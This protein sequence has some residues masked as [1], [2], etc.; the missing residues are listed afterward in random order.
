MRLA[1]PFYLSE[2]VLA[3][4]EKILGKYLCTKING[5][6][7]AGMIVETEAYMAPDDKA[8]HAFQN[9]RTNRTK[10]MFESGGIAYVYLCYGIHHLFNIVTGPRDMAHAILVR[11]VEP[12]EGLETMLKRRKMNQ[13]SYRLTGGPGSLSSALGITTALTGS[14]L[15]RKDSKVWLEDRG[16]QVQSVIKSPRV[17]V[18]YAEECALWNWRFRVKDNLWTSKAK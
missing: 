6:L 11:A 10:V 12:K 1:D 7:T 17:G 4:S 5:K 13:A 9:R 16:F 8:S 3:L 2:D 14:P 18:D 15:G